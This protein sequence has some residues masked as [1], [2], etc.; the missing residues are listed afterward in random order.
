MGGNGSGRRILIIEDDGHINGIIRDGLTSAGFVCTQAYSGS[1]GKMNLDAQEYQ[2]IVLDLMLPGLSGEQFMHYLR[3]ELKSAIP[4]IILSAKDGLD[5][6]LNLFAL[7]A[8]DYVTKPFELEELIARIHVHIQRN[9]ADEPVKAF[10]HKNLLLDTGAYS[11]TVHGTVL[12]LT[13]QE[14]R[15]VELLVKNPGRVFTKQDLYEL[16]WEELYMGED[17]TVTVHISNI[18]SK[19]KPYDSESYIDTIWGIGFRLSK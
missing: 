8:D 12:N 6:K 17:K 7:G 1:E 5:H 13:R 9:T 11:V 19:I 3:K 18:R 10:R 15:I 14:Y 16:A 4:V 2:L